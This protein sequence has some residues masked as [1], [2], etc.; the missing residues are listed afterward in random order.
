MEILRSDQ[1]ASGSQTHFWYLYRCDRFFQHRSLKY[2]VVIGDIAAWLQG[3]E[4]PIA[5][6]LQPVVV[7][8]VW[9]GAVKNLQYNHT[10]S[11]PLFVSQILV[12]QISYNRNK[13]FD[14]GV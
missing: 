12:C 7:G 8:N 9:I 6:S 3:K 13:S 1:I 4:K 11:F 5:N 14:L 2:A 10:V